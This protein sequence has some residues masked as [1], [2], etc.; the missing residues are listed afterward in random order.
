MRSDH[1]M[2]MVGI[3]MRS[4]RWMCGA[5]ASDTQLSAELI[6]QVGAEVMEVL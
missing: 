2:R 1:D 5:S 4:V 6:R 3:E